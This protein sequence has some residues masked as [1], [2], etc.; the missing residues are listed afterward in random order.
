M[1]N[2]LAGREHLYNN[3]EKRGYAPSRIQRCFITGL[4]FI[5]LQ[6]YAWGWDLALELG[7]GDDSTDRI[8]FGIQWQWEKKWFAQGNWYLGGYWEASFSYWDG[9]KGWTGNASLFEGGITPVFRFQRH[10]PI[11]GVSPY[12]EAAIGVHG[13]SETTLGDNDFSIP[14][15]FGSHLGTGIR[16]G[17]QK[18][19]ELGYRFQHLSNAVLGDPNPGINFHLLRLS[20]HF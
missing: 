19:F 8:G 18:Q 16:F 12:L 15:A 4:L 1:R 2:A 10:S 3:N 13:M 6:T 7:T 17:G 5:L 9:E 14:F 11:Y 20:Y